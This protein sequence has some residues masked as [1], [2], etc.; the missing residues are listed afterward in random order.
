M[1]DDPHWGFILTAYFAT[2]CVLSGLVYWI[3]TDYR[4]LKRAL[5]A[6]DAAGTKRRSNGE[7]G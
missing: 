3:V 5:A 1:M 4:L 6:L 2:I 7:K